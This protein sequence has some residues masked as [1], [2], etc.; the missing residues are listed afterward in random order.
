MR[1]TNIKPGTLAEDEILVRVF[2]EVEIENRHGRIRDLGTRAEA[3][4]WRALKYLLVNS[5]R[6]VDSEELL[7]MSYEGK[8]VTMPDGAMRTR[9]SRTRALLKPLK[10]SHMQ[11]LILF[12]EGRVRISPDYVIHSDEQA[13]N[14]LMER[15]KAADTGNAGGLALCAEALE[16]MRGVYMGHTGRAGWLEGH[17]DYYRRE[18]V[19]LGFET[20]ERMR[21][22]D[23]DSAC[24]LLWRRAI[25]IAP[26]AET[27]HRAIVSFMMERRQELEL[28]R[29]LSQLTAKGAKWLEDFE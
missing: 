28:L 12:G 27:L 18:F 23:T 13:F 26:E 21:A 6:D 11:G 17:R 19:R 3:L 22:L 7:E 29:Y 5:N 1:F 2:G 8:Q 10:L 4:T 14:D 25:V 16:L 24:G 20:L 15:I 9:L